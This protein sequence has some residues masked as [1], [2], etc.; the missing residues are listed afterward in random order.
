M[1]RKAIAIKN[2]S[3]EIRMHSASGGLFSA[4]AEYVL[5][6]SGIVYGVGLDDS[7]DVS[8]FRIT[9]MHNLRILNGSKYV[10][11][12]TQ[13]TFLSVKRDLESGHFVIFS[14]TP[15][16][17]DG[18]RA[19]LG[20]EYQNLLMCDIVCHGCPSPRVF[21]D[22]ILNLPPD[23]NA[24]S[25][26]D[27]EFGWSKQKWSITRG[28]KKKVDSIELLAYKKLFYAH[29]AH[30][31]SCYHCPYTTPYRNSDITMAD[32]WGVNY[33]LP[34]F[35]DDL[36]VSIALIHTPKGKKVIDH[37]TD[38]LV[39][40]EI[41]ITDCLQPQLREPIAR[42]AERQRFWQ[43]YFQ[44]GYKYSIEKMIS[45]SIKERVIAALPYNVRKLIKK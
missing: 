9:D 20:K 38:N 35:K 17:V 45:I 25:F 6:K 16:Q 21:Q 18:L 29:L 36:G 5:N 31:P 7:F 13:N 41:K 42:P 43:L 26:R 44:K 28:K 22:F 2:R 30:R 32:F 15:C 27:K 11:C 4:L 19:F 3:N 40:R 8:Y 37:I 1:P 23:I 39:I 34:E 10:Q 24:I 33:A 14:G 12:P